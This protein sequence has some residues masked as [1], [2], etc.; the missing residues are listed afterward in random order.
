ME[1]PS[2]KNTYQHI[3]IDKLTIVD[4]RY[5]VGWNDCHDAMSTWLE[6]QVPTVEELVNAMPTQGTIAVTRHNIADA[7]LR[8]ITR[9]LTG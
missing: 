8:L 3:D 9:K 5:N 2:K 4:T 6:W 1:K 7:I